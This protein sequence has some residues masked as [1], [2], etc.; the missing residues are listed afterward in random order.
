MA[1]PPSTPSNPRT[2]SVELAEESAPTAGSAWAPRIFFLTLLGLMVMLAGVEVSSRLERPSLVRRDGEGGG[3]PDLVFFQKGPASRRVAW[4][5]YEPDG[6]GEAPRVIQRVPCAPAD[7]VTGDIRL[8][9]DGRG[10]YADR[11]TAKEGGV[12][13]IL[14]LH[15]FADGRLF[16][17]D[18]SF[19]LKGATAIL[20]TPGGLLAQW[21]RMG[22]AGKRV[23]AWY[24][25]GAQGETLW[26]WQTTRWERALPR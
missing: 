22:G 17:R 15:T 21:R 3:E 9:R 18:E 14:W 7:T 10:V 25:L 26:S 24:E 4:L 16:I 5:L 1:S 19:A 13:E 6:K 12:P 11:R 2:D 20:Q 23:A 8:T